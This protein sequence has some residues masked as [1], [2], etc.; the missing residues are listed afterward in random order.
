M[1]RLWMMPICG[2]LEKQ[3]QLFTGPDRPGTSLQGCAFSS[4]DCYS[5]LRLTIPFGGPKKL[6][7]TAELW[8]FPPK[9]QIYEDRPGSFLELSNTHCRGFS[10]QRSTTAGTMSLDGCR[11]N[12]QYSG[13]KILKGNNLFCELKFN[14]SVENSTFG[15]A[16][17]LVT[18]S[19]PFVSTQKISE[20]SPALYISTNFLQ[21]LSYNKMESVGTH[22][23]Y[24]TFWCIWRVF[25][26]GFSTSRFGIIMPSNSKKAKR[27]NA[28]KK[29]DQNPVPSNTAPASPLLPQEFLE[30]FKGLENREWDSFLGEELPDTECTEFQP[31]IG[32]EENI[33]IAT[34]TALDSFTKFLVD[35]QTAAQNAKRQREQET[36]RK[37]RRG[38]YTGQ[39]NQSKWRDNKKAKKLEALGFVGLGDFLKAKAAQKLEGRTKLLKSL[40]RKPRRPSQTCNT[41]GCVTWIRRNDEKVAKYQD[42]GK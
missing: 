18:S 21:E 39:S 14:S 9:I 28:R 22:H 33:E 6:W 35:A 5:Q 13:V 15:W 29:P 31:S 37:R 42:K 4:W 41:F 27:E 2:E 10:W 24:N 16:V 11:P 38:P 30:T 20:M 7:G 3:M 12:V 19:E 34:E 23:P 26:L 25:T 1:A 8:V 17:Q 36:G 40:L 32:D